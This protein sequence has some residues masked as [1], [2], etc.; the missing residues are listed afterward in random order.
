MQAEQRPPWTAL[1]LLAMTGAFA[2]FVLF[3]R[4]SAAPQGPTILDRLHTAGARLETT[5]GMD[6]YGDE[7]AVRR[8]IHARDTEEDL[9][10]ETV[11]IDEMARSSGYKLDASQKYQV[12]LVDVP[13]AHIEAQGPV[14]GDNTWN[15]FRCWVYDRDAALVSR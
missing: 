7:L 9:V 14:A 3:D 15:G 11:R 1:G 13:F 4:P 8:V 10:A 6:C 12:L 2:A 5:D